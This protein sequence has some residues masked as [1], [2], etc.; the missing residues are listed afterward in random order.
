MRSLDSCIRKLV[1]TRVC[2]FF[3][4]FAHRFQP[5]HACEIQQMQPHSC[6]S[7]APSRNPSLGISTPFSSILHLF[8]ILTSFLTIFASN[9]MS[10]VISHSIMNPISL[11][12]YSFH[13]IMNLISL[14]LQVLP[15]Y[16]SRGSTSQALVWY[17]ILT[18]ETRGHIRTMGFELIICLLPERF[19]SAILAQTLAKR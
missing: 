19:T 15:P 16:S 12:H 13:L 4:S 2:L 17:S 11:S 8:A 7:M 5:T 10:H 14:F 9:C 6:A 1:L 18:K 3:S